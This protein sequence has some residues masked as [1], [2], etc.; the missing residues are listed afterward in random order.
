MSANRRHQHHHQRQHLFSLLDSQVCL[1]WSAATRQTR[2]YSFSRQLRIPTSQCAFKGTS[3]DA[4][5]AAPVNWQPKF[6][7]GDVRFV[8]NSCMVPFVGHLYASVGERVK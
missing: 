5:A 6:V 1:R 3:A 2:S 7:P 8:A 4:A